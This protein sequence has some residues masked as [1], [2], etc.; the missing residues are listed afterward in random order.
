VALLAGSG[1]ANSYF[2]V[3][4]FHAL[5]S[6]GYGKLLL[7]KFALFSAMFA[8]GGWNLFIV[9]NQLTSLEV[10]SRDAPCTALATVAR[11]VWIEIGL[12]TVVLLVV[13][14]LGILPPAVHS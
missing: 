11:N 10:P 4:N 7:L 3:G 2:L 1:I 5:L 14:L 13:G 6:T 9:R 8:I 12:G